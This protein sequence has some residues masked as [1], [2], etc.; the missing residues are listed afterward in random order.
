MR[1]TPLFLLL[2][3]AAQFQLVSPMVLPTPG[4]P[5]R[6]AVRPLSEPPSLSQCSPGLR[7]G[8]YGAS[9]RAIGR[10]ISTKAHVYSIARWSMLVKHH[11]RMNQVTLGAANLDS[12]QR[13]Q[14]KDGGGI[15]PVRATQN[16][17]EQVV[18]GLNLCP[19]ARG[20][21]DENIVNIQVRCVGVRQGAVRACLSVWAQ[22]GRQ[23]AWNMRGSVTH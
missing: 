17:V 16:W 22:R 4:M 8:T 3:A 13:A 14:G 11:H 9:R 21:L 6:N 1:Q 23:R 15:C 12:A 7:A 5:C 10:G 20:A 18:V 2:L 19:W